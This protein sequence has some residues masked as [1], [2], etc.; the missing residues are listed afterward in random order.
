MSVVEVVLIVS[1]CVIPIV[2]IFFVVQPRFKRR[3][4]IPQENNQI[5]SNEVKAEPKKEEESNVKAFTPSFV[6]SYDASDEF[7]D[8]LKEK[9][10][11]IETP[12]RKEIMPD[13]MPTVPYTRR[14]VV[15]KDES[16]PVAEQ[17]EDLSP[18]LFA[19]I[20]SGALDRKYFN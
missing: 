1:F 12:K 20:F 13:A 17:L 19:M 8:Y 2:A 14:R 4:L 9:K 18:E 7:K 15:K 16:K 3:H 10:S 6:T 5:E 11:H